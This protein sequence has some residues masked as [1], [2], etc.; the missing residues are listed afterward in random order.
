MQNIDSFRFEVK[1]RFQRNF[2]V[3]ASSTGIASRLIELR[4]KCQFGVMLKLK[5]TGA[6][7]LSVMVVCVFTVDNNALAVRI[8]LSTVAKEHR[9]LYSVASWSS[10]VA[11]GCDTHT[12]LRYQIAGPLSPIRQL[13]RR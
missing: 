8:L 2:W 5:I 13:A 6:A 9:R 4:S 1:L 3:N 12:Y 7:M 11:F 10:L